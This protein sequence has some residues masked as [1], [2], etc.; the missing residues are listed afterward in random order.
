MLRLPT[1]EELRAA[2]DAAG[3]AHHEYERNALG[4]RRDDAW[5]S[6]YAAYV[7]GRLGDFADPTWLARALEEVPAEEDWA[8]EAALAVARLLGTG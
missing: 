4:G 8:E 5:A 1:S 7:L 6:W 3:L 2:L